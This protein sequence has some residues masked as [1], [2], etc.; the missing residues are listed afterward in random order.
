MQTY[1]VFDTPSGAVEMKKQHVIYTNGVNLVEIRNIR[2]IDL[3]KTTTNDIV[4]IY[5][6]Y[7][8]EAARNAIIREIIIPFKTNGNNINYHHLSVLADHMTHT[9]GL[10][11][12][13]R[14]GIN[15]LATDPLSRAS[16]EKNMEQLMQ[17]AA[18]G[19]VDHMTSVSSRIM[20]GKVIK[21]GTGLCGLT[22]DTQLVE[23]SEFVESETTN[24]INSR[25]NFKKLTESSMF[26][27]LMTQQVDT[28]VPF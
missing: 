19:E 24:G 26:D 13:D 11:S 7:G 6:T 14:H 16:F 4:E 27:E 21:G 10:T 15:K 25:L 8:I 28:F 5:R 17:A 18:F 20:A 3:A 12:I 2:G 1:C 23:R 9:G 22:L